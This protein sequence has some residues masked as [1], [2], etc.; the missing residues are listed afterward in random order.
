[1]PRQKKPELDLFICQLASRQTLEDKNKM[2]QSNNYADMIY[3]DCEGP[4]TDPTVPQKNWSKC[5]E[6]LLSATVD[7]MRAQAM[8][9]QLFDQL[10]HYTNNFE[11]NIKYIEL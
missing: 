2:H 10:S 3:L 8:M 7:A 11:N 6:I 9:Q 4:A 1:M 5:S